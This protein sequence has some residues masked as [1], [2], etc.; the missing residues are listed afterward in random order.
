MAYVKYRFRAECDD[1]VSALDKLLQ[2]ERVPYAL[3]A[4]PV[5]IDHPTLGVV[6]MPDR[7]CRLYVGVAVCIDWLR[8][9]MRRVP[10]GQV[11]L[12]TLAPEDQYT[13]ERDYTLA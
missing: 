12:Q 7:E 1:D 13:G 9:C 2:A 4:W 8:Q 6:D 3:R 10:D 11:M 5:T